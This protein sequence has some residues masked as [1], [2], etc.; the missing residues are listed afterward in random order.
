MHRPALTAIVITSHW[1]HTIVTF[2]Q[3]SL[4]SAHRFHTSGDSS[5]CCLLLSWV[6]TIS[7]G[8]RPRSWVSTVETFWACVTLVSTSVRRIRARWTSLDM[9]TTVTLV[10]DGTFSTIVSLTFIVIVTFWTGDRSMIF[11]YWTTNFCSSLAFCYRRAWWDT[12]GIMFWIGAI[13]TALSF[14]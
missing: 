10:T 6:C 5:T 3:C 13:G 12:S 1:I 4:S 2:F 7:T 11:F 9:S 8:L 14:T